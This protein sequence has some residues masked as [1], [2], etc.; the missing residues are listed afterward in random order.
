MRK[1]L[2]YLLALI[3]VL[4]F[5]TLSLAESNASI[6]AVETNLSLEKNKKPESGMEWRRRNSEIDAQPQNLRFPKVIWGGNQFV[7]VGD[8]Y[9]NKAIIMTSLDGENWKARYHGETSLNEVAWNGNLY[10][11]VGM[12]GVIL[13]SGDG[14]SWT[15]RDSGVNDLL[16]GVTWGNNQFVVLGHGGLFLTSPDGKEWT[17]H[18]TPSSYFIFD[19]TWDG[20]KF[21]AVGMGNIYVSHDGVEWEEYNS[22]FNAGSPTCIVW[23][24][25]QFAVGDSWGNVHISP[26]GKKWSKTET[27]WAPINDVTWGDGKFVAVSGDAFVADPLTGDIVG[28]ESIFGKI[29]TSHDGLTWTERHLTDSSFMSVTWSGSQFLAVD[30]SGNFF[31]SCRP[32]DQPALNISININNSFLKTDVPPVI[33]EG[34]TLVPLRAIF[35][36]LGMDVQY[37][38]QTQTII[39]VKDDSRI[40]LNVDS[41]QAM[42]NG[43]QVTLDVPATIIDG[44][45]MVPVRFIAEST[46]QKVVWDGGNRTVNITAKD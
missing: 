39:G 41:I 10:V 18:Y 11:A 38:E 4:S 44:R 23:S 1:K 7:A 17:K 5:S 8:S 13:T 31:T 35:E 29:Y 27:C 46:G 28:D 34:R 33:L 2:M 36:S 12:T 20:K 22:N 14:V 42:V 21:V 19:V 15:K 6:M 3:V 40:E 26:D 43:K 37:V 24:G 32:E 25:N 45:T 30:S 9:D 16:M